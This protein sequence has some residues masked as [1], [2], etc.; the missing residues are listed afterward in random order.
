MA[1]KSDFLYQKPENS[2]AKASARPMARA[3]KRFSI[4][5]RLPQIWGQQ[6]KLWLQDVL[7]W[8]KWFILVFALAVALFAL[9]AWMLDPATMPVRRVWVE[10]Q[11][12]G[13]QITLHYV[14][15][16]VLQA[17]VQKFAQ[18][19]FWGVDIHAV[20][21]AVLALP[22]VKAA[23]VRRVWPD[24]LHIKVQE[25]VPVARWQE[26]GIAGEAEIE[27]HVTLLDENGE[28]FY[29]NTPPP[30]GMPIFYGSL[31]RRDEILRYY[32]RLLPLARSAGLAVREI[33]ATPGDS[34]EARMDNDIIIVLDSGQ[35]YPQAS[36]FFQM[37]PSL[38][39]TQKKQISRVDLRYTNG[40]AVQWRSGHNLPA[41]QPPG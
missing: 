3:K 27:S 24:A 20:R 41:R 6:A 30:P 26:T 21:D 36:K 38:P 39:D 15:P 33:H 4:R 19:G 7:L 28:L 14:K 23:S 32:G 22:W 13:V 5:P 18:G 29:I 31:S 25:R 9:G 1:V 2:G 8:L 34:W 16:E 40:F 17:A 11:Y 37:Y 12:E 35:A 10:G